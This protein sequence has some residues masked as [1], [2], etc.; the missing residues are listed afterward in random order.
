M[1]AVRVADSHTLLLLYP[2]WSKIFKL[3]EKCDTDYG[4]KMLSLIA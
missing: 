4:V 2:A 3:Y 1:Q